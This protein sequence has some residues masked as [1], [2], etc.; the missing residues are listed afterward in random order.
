MSFAQV[1]HLFEVSLPVLDVI[2]P[3]VSINVDPFL[4]VPWL[5]SEVVQP[6]DCSSQ[7]DQ[8]WE[9]RREMGG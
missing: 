9:E 3:L 1:L 4:V 5:E 7:G 8:V 2:F 6:S